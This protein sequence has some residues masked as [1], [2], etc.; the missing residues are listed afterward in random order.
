MEPTRFLD[1]SS[2]EKL[3]REHFN[4]LT[5]FAITFVKD[6]E[7]AREIVQEAFVNLWERKGEIDLSK[8]V[9]SYLSTMVRNRCLNHIRDNKKFS[10]ELLDIE[11]APENFPYEQPD[12]LVEAE[13]RA[14]IARG[15]DELPEKCREI[16]I[17]SRSENLKYHEIAEKLKISVKTVETQMSK[18][19][20]HL[21]IRL[22]EYITLIIILLNIILL[23]G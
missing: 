3:F 1:E 5:H 16:F 6:D 19:L 23:S 20:Q 7:T 22:S 18:A 9:K 11:Q 10:K 2:F 13:I 8:P 15:I 17:M 14:K 21:R 4:G 12:K